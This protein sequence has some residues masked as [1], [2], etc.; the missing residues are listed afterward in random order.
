MANGPLTEEDKQRIDDN[1]RQ[2]NEADEQI[3]LAEQAGL[4]V[5]ALRDTAREQR[6]QLTKIKQTYFPG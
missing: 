1:L 4:D 5:K 2:L 6:A 3:R